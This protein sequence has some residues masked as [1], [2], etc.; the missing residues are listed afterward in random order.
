MATYFNGTYSEDFGIASTEGGLKDIARIEVL[1]G[2][3]GVLYGR[4]AVGGAMNFVTKRPTDEYEVVLDALVGNFD[5]Y[6]FNYVLSGPIIRDTLT[7]RFTG[8]DRSQ[9]GFIDE[10]S[11]FGDDINDYGDENYSLALEYTPTD[12]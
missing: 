2:P 7:A 4:S 10:T 1:R 5:T 3:Q 8:S 6:E 12:T 11:R 9:D